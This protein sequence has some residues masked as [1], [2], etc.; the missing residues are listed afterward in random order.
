MS[1]SAL[2]QH[3][4][5]I[6][7]E[8]CMQLQPGDQ[9]ILREY[10]L[11]VA[12]IYRRKR[13]TIYGLSRSDDQVLEESVR[14]KCAGMPE[15]RIRKIVKILDKWSKFMESKIMEFETGIKPSF[16]H[17]SNCHYTREFLLYRISIVPPSSL[18]KKE[19]I[20]HMFPPSLGKRKKILSFQLQHT[21]YDPISASKVITAVDLNAFEKM[22][23]IELLPGKFHN[24]KVVYATV[25]DNGF[26]MTAYHTV[27]EDN[28]GQ[29]AKLCIY[30]TTPILL[31]SLKKD[32]K[33]AITNPY[34]K[35]GGEDGVCF[36][37]QESPDEVIVILDKPTVNCKNEK[38]ESK[39]CEDHKREGNEFFK[40]EKFKE[41]INSYTEAIRHNEINP[42]Y[43]SNR[44]QCYIRLKQFEKALSDAEQAT[45]LDNKS[46]KFKY[47]LAMAWSGLGDHEESC[48]I[49]ESIEGMTSFT[50]ALVKERILF[51][52]TRGEFDFEEMARKAKKCEEIEIGEFVGSISIESSSKHGHAMI[53]TRDIKKG[54]LISVSKAAGFVS[55]SKD[56]DL[57]EIPFREVSPTGETTSMRTKLLIQSLTESVVESKLAAFRV[58]PLF[59]KRDHHEH[60]PIQY[61]TSKGY[62]YIRDKDV[63]PYQMQQLRDIATRSEYS[64]TPHFDKPGYIRPSGVWPILPYFNHSCIGN[65]WQKC[66][67]DILII[68]AC[69]DIP[70]GAELTTSF[71]DTYAFITMEDRKFKLEFGWDWHCNCDLCEF[72]SNPRLKD[73][74][75]RAVLLHNRAEK[76]SSDPNV[77]KLLNEAFDLAEELK[78]GKYRF[79]S[80][81]WNTIIT[82]TKPWS[83]CGNKKEIRKYLGVMYRARTFLCELDLKHQWYYWKNCVGLANRLQLNVDFKL[84]AESKFKEVESFIMD[85]A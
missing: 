34:Y 58:F 14:E 17:G 80:A 62:T 63:P 7:E 43:W 76:V 65:F 81:V 42:I 30:N 49:L 11:P 27:V 75:Q 73:A 16:V 56:K 46:D 77:F 78:L 18:G 33:I 22:K 20:E 70:E 6:M 67:R 60:I 82:L 1:D 21:I 50:A 54:D 13:K 57:K 8:Y 35:K 5:P 19:N 4:N 24:N 25:I 41:A 2:E 59:N 79:N 44:A 15:K 61:Y 52:N 12:E 66:Y 64:Y 28:F 39:S 45:L 74:L 53:A 9:P 83:L 48:K 3:I 85:V 37:R 51:G 47:R 72:E 36:I 29:C 10:F 55:Q 69:T 68:R 32:T 71:I 38:T 23:I 26:L 40:S 31:N 84:E